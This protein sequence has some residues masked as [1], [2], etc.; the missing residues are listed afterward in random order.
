MK[1]VILG[2]FGG[3]VFIY[4]VIICLSIFTIQ[5]RKNEVENCLA[6]IVEQTLE[7][8]Y[9]PLLMRTNDYQV[10]DATIVKNQIIKDIERRITSNST[11]T[12]TILACDMDKGILSVRIDEAYPMPMGKRR[13]WHFT[14]TAIVE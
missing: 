1:N 9:V 7:E 10:P 14:K 3:I 8:N 13:A 12:I 6:Q 2:L 5:S 4:S 11:Y